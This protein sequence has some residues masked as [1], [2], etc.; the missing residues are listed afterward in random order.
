MSYAPAIEVVGL[1]KRFGDVVALDGVNLAVQPGT[2]YGLLGPNGAGKTTTVRVLT[3]IIRPDAG[4]ARVL[5]L[6]VVDQAQ[7]VRASS[8]INPGPRFGFGPWNCWNDLALPMRRIG[9]SRRSPAVCAAGW[10]LPPLWCTG[11][12]CCSL[13]SPP[14]G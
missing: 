1:S 9:P 10:T 7:E 6:D 3:T 4:S 8:P 2:G 11:R 5:G 13:T 12:R 14:P